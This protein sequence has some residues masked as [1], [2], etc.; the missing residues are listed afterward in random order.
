MKGGERR[1]IVSGN[2]RRGESL[3]TRE[4]PERRVSTLRKRVTL[5]AT[6]IERTGPSVSKNGNS[7]MIGVIFLGNSVKGRLE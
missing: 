1:G 2:G 4:Q 7:L 3:N 6:V 5:H